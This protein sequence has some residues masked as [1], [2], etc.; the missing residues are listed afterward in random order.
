MAKKVN[1]YFETFIK[2]ID[3][4]CQAANHLQE[5]MSSFTIES[6]PEWRKLMHGIEHKEDLLRQEMMEKLAKEFVTPIERED[7]IEMGNSLDDVTDMIEDILIHIYMYNITSIREE[8]VEFSSVIVKC[9]E[10]LKEAMLE[11]PNFHK[12]NTLE[13][14]FVKVDQLEDEGDL[15]Y[16]NAIHT[17]YSDPNK[18]PIK[19]MVWSELFESLEDCC[20]TCGKV[21]DVMQMVVMK[22]S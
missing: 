5:L 8:A 13:S 3:Y 20:D 11:F 18:D 19:L 1:Y 7:I 9:C 14:Y 2:M 4:S 6:L 12:S 15:L 16:I 21:I 10:A 17:L 22:N